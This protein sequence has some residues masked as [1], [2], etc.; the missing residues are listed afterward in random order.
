[1]RAECR[2]LSLGLGWAGRLW[3]HELPACQAELCLG[4]PEGHVLAGEL[5]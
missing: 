1:M 3:G 5:V 4:F 2:Q